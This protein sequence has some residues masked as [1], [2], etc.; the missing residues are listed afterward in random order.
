MIWAIPR[1]LASVGAL[2]HGIIVYLF[3]GTTPSRSA[4]A[5]I[6]IY[7]MTKG[8]GLDFFNFLIR[9]FKNARGEKLVLI[10]PQEG[11]KNVLSDSRGVDF[12]VRQLRMAGYCVL[13]N[14]LPSDLVKEIQEYSL[15]TESVLRNEKT[16]AIYQ[17]GKSNSVRYDF[18]PGDMLQTKLFNDILTSAFV[19]KVSESYLECRPWLD[20]ISMWWHTDY[21]KGPDSEA[22]QLYHFDM[23]RPKWLKIFVYLTDVSVENGPHCFVEGSHRSGAVPWK[24]LRRG[25]SRISDEEV[26]ES[27][28]MQKEVKFIAP[29]GTVIVED[30]RGLHKGLHVEEGD[31]LIFQMQLSNSAFGAKYP[32]LNSE[33]INAELLNRLKK[34]KLPC[35]LF[36]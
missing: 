25:Y 32:K 11:I 20:V 14:K 12:V 31:R 3:W 4:Q 28:G 18:S 19:L 5:M 23:D 6:H 26:Y 22:A 15:Q 36:N 13:D 1:L 34:I 10:P 17:R 29:A 27:F 35:T 7:C 8:F 9:I 24:L 30:T 21:S 2:V 16:V 33:K